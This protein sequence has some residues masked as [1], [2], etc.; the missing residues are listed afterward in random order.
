MMPNAT[1]AIRVDSDLD[2]LVYGCDK[3]VVRRSG[4]VGICDDGGVQR[5][6]FGGSVWRPVRAFVW[7]EYEQ[8][9]GR[10]S[11]LLWPGYG[12][13]AIVPVCSPL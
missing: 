2:L 8:I 11:A 4:P 13:H 6:S 10:C 12:A 3:E 5:H 9:R 7:T 1:V